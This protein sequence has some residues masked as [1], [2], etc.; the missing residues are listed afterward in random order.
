MMFINC[1]RILISNFTQFWKI[2]VN[3][4][5]VLILIALLLLPFINTFMLL[6]YSLFFTQLKDLFL[7]LSFINLSSY[8]Q[9]VYSCIMEFINLVNNL[10]QTNPSCLIYSC[11]VLFGIFPFLINLSDVA[12]GEVMYGS[13]TSLTKVSYLGSYIKKIG[14]SILYSICKTIITLPTFCLCAVGSFYLVKLSLTNDILLIFIP[15]ILITL[16]ALVFALINCI[17]S[18]WMPSIIVFPGNI[19]S[20]FFKGLKIGTKR[21]FRNLSTIFCINFL[22]FSTVCL[23]GPVSLIIV[24]PFSYFLNIIFQMVMMFSTQGMR[25]YVDRDTIVSPKKLEETDSF[26]KAKKVI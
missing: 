23:F 16:F 18:G 17:F 13:M 21:F 3:K 2:V 26:K 1:F 24:V 25:F 8:V 10:Y 11:F 4:I 20:A 12:L 6:D 5:L 7:N 22:M 9:T 15:L 14:K 19:T